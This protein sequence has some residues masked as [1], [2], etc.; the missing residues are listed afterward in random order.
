MVVADR[1]RIRVAERHHGHLGGG[2]RP[3][4]R[5]R[6]H[7]VIGAGEIHG[8]DLLESFCAPG[9]ADDHLGAAP[10]DAKA[11]EAPVGGSRQQLGRRRQ[12]EGD[13]SR[14]RLAQREHQVSVGGASLLGRHLLQ[15]HRRDQ[16]LEDGKRPRQADAADLSTQASDQRVGGDEA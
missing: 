11:V 2:P 1:N 4:T 3:D 12:R 6:E 16:G 7:P 15:D 13:R 9:G 5:E 14:R 10:L 8:E